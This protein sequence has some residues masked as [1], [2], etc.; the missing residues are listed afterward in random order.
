MA[1]HR[2]RLPDGR[3]IELGTDDVDGGLTYPDLDLHS[4]EGIP[5]RRALASMSQASHQEKLERYMQHVK[6]MNAMP[7]NNVEL[8][9]EHSAVIDQ[10]TET[11]GAETRLAEG[12][13]SITTLESKRTIING[14]VGEVSIDEALYKVKAS[15]V[16]VNGSFSN[17]LEDIAGSLTVHLTAV[18]DIPILHPKTEVTAKLIVMPEWD[19]EARSVDNSDEKHSQSISTTD[20][21]LQSVNEQEADKHQIIETLG[22]SYVYFYGERPRMY[23]FSGSLLNSVNKQWKNN[24][25]ENYR[26][27]F[28]GTKCAENKTRTYIM[29]EDMIIEGY[30]LNMNISLNSQ[31]TKICPFSFN[32]YVT[33]TLRMNS[34]DLID[35]AQ[36][37][38]S[39]K[40]IIDYNRQRKHV[41]QQEL[42]S[43]I[44]DARRQAV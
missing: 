22:E 30:I 32:M 23:S 38:R 9:F 44:S 16:S 1:R 13:G 5:L 4:A 3:F 18:R 33:N 43:Y 20:F 24:F 25:M 29:Y 41:A 19:N 42:N 21:I 28:R 31:E 40:N 17:N 10:L 14:S 2:V 6:D 37:K 26:N 39:I 35:P 7:K 34:D 8:I 36:Q 11:S 27:I 15:N 12:V